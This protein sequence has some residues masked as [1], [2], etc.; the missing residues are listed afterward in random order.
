MVDPK[1]VTEWIEKA[2]KDLEFARISLEENLEFYPQICFL[3][4]EAIEKYLKA[5]IIAN[6]LDFQK[7]HDLGRLVKICGQKD[8]EFN[9][10]FDKVADLNSYYIET[11]YPDFEVIVSKSQAEDALEVAEEIAAFVK[12]KIN[13]P[14]EEQ[15]KEESA[16]SETKGAVEG[17]VVEEEKKE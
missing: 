14:A 8:N 7:T 2:D 11:R 9:E 10:Y 13:Q 4:H 3:L 12:Q 5:Y 6:E 16:P 17:E 1:L 15:A